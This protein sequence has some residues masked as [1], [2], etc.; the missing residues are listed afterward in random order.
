V[1]EQL[2]ETANSKPFKK[3]IT[4]KMAHFL[5]Q[6]AVELPADGDEVQAQ[7]EQLIR[8]AYIVAVR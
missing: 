6:P 4:T 3:V 7:G 5:Q 2:L 8:L 1:H